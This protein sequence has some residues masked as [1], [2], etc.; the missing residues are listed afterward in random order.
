MET[1]KFEIVMPVRDE[2]PPYLVRYPGVA[3][4]CNADQHAL[5]AWLAQEVKCVCQRLILK[6]D[7]FTTVAG[8]ID[9]EKYCPVCDGTTRLTLKALVE[10]LEVYDAN[11]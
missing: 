8:Q 1:P 3:S 2:T 7:S 11:L 6:A 9:I 10:K 5:D 4:Q